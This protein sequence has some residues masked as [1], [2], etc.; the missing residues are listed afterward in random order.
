MTISDPR[1]AT[2]ARV[3]GTWLVGGMIVMAV[4]L[5]VFAVWFQ[6]QQT[7]RCLTFYGSAAAHR[8]QAAP[9]VEIWWPDPATGTFSNPA[10]R[11]DVSTA[12][13]IVHLRRGLVEDAN[14]AW[15]RAQPA[16]DSPT[17]AMAF[18]DAVGDPTPGTV[19]R[20][21]LD[22]GGGWL[23]VEGSPGAV[24]LGRLAP[25]LRTWLADVPRGPEQAIPTDR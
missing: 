7:R 5:A 16:A 23:A 1:R 2:A 10:G 6:R 22:A 8:L 24:A 4:A 14:F 18:F 25:G 13:G 20:V 11:A 12:R 19:L 15:D 3:T 17:F 9:R 21:G